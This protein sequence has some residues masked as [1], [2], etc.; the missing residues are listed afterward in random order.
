M[1]TRL[2]SSLAI[3][4]ATWLASGCAMG[5]SLPP[6][7]PISEQVRMVGDFMEVDLTLRATG[8]RF[9]CACF[10][11]TWMRPPRRAGDPPRYLLPDASM[12]RDRLA[13]VAREGSGGT[14]LLRARLPRP[15][16]DDVSQIGVTIY[17][18]AGPT[19]ESVEEI[20]RQY[21]NRV[22]YG[23]EMYR[24]QVTSRSGG[25]NPLGLMGLGLI[26]LGVLVRG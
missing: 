5:S 16:D 13:F 17:Q 6:V 12:P 21:C 4:L 11:L 2:G 1:K 24:L 15:P 7:Q 9:A 23:G 10:D 8:G 25:I 18:L 3:A 26:V 19:P 20:A 22:V 14:Q